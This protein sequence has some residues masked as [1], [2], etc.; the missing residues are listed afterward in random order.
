[1]AILFKKLRP[2]AITPQ[3]AF[4]YDAAWDLHSTDEA[5]IKIGE[6]SKIGTGIAIAIPNGYVGRI[7]ERSGLG[8]KGLA[9]RGG[10]VD[11][12]YRGELKVLM[13]NLSDRIFHVLPGMR[14]AQLLI[15]AVILDSLQESDVLIDADR[16][17][18]GFGSTGI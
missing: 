7:A 11:S 13:Q 5:I 10:V 17:D 14:I 4:E 9:V 15:H 18:K 1:M 3:K 16:G 2:E 12:G 8:A 6:T